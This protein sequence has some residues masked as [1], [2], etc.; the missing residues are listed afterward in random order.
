MDS[1]RPSWSWRKIENSRKKKKFLYKKPRGFWIR[2]RIGA[3]GGLEWKMEDDPWVWGWN[4]RRFPNFGRYSRFFFWSRKI[5]DVPA[6]WG[7][8]FTPKIQGYSVLFGPKNPKKFQIFRNPNTPQKFKD[9]PFFCPKNSKKF[10]TLGSRTSRIFRIFLDPKKFKDISFF[11]PPKFKEIP[12][13]WRSKHTP[14]NSRIFPILFAPKIQR[15]SQILAPR[16]SR[17]CQI[18]DPKPQRNSQ[19]LAQ[20]TQSNSQFLAQNLKKFP[21]SGPKIK[22]YSQF[23]WPKKLKNIPSFSAPDPWTFP[24]FSTDKIPNSQ[25]IF[26]GGGFGNSGFCRFFGEDFRGFSLFDLISKIVKN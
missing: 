12:N 5:R 16:N 11:W 22:K 14:K 15:N 4:W 9:I 20:K 8:K 26:L 24:L 23:F 7:E 10:P 13:F 17:R 2:R 3:R 1:R 25:R 18:F 6:F 19:F 21:F